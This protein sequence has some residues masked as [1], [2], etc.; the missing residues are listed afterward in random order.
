[1]A[2]ERGK[3]W[4]VVQ[5]ILTRRGIGLKRFCEMFGFVRSTVYNWMGQDEILDDIS[6]S[7]VRALAELDRTTPAEIY[8]R[9]GIDLFVTPYINEHVRFEH[10]RLY[11]LVNEVEDK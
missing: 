5:D 10:L 4:Q 7:F 11:P 9:L 6:H 8:R 3:L 2:A 1:M